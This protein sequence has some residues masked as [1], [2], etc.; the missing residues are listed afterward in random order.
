MHGEPV[1]VKA[2]LGLVLMGGKGVIINIY[3]VISYPMIQSEI[4]QKDFGNLKG[5]GLFLT[6]P[7]ITTFR[8][9]KGFAHTIKTTI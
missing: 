7:E 4:G 3:N 9:E 8:T 1:A 2:K 5:M 6:Q